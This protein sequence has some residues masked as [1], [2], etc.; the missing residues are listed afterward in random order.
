MV[1][2]FGRPN[3]CLRGAHEEEEDGCGVDS[4]EVGWGEE[5][6]DE[7]G[8]EED[9]ELGEEEDDEQGEEEDSGEE[10]DSEDTTATFFGECALAPFF[11]PYP[12]NACDCSGDHDSAMGIRRATQI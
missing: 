7:L 5:E 2:P 11:Y 6:D 12:C 4:P 1:V 10:Q 9:N 3:I 8:E